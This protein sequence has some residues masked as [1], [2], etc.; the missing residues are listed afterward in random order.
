[1]TFSGKVY[2]C[3][4]DRSPWQS[5][6]K[7]RADHRPHQIVGLPDYTVED[8]AIGTEHVLFLTTTD[9]VLG[10]GMNT[11]GQL[12][13]SHLSLVKDPEIINE[14]SNK[15]IKQIS[16]GRTH[17]AAWTAL[18]LPNRK[19]GITKNLSFGLPSEIPPQY[20]LLQGLPIKSIQDRL[21]FLYNFADK[22]YSS[23]TLIPLATQQIEMHIPPLEG[24]ISPKLKPLLAPRVYTLPFVRCIGKTMVQGKNYGPQ[25]VVR[26]IN[27]E[28]ELLFHLQISLH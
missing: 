20:D 9:K 22:V 6:V 11:E 3:G 12:G 5:T 13:L 26:R 19:P 28:G 27:Q 10:W 25:I 2:V 17:S 23:W 18:P 14:L 24:L 16:T 1:M 21:R 15:G 4:I 8:F 7:E